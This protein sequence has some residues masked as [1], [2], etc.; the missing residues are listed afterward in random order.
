MK[1]FPLGRKR[2]CPEQPAIPSGIRVYAIG[3]VHGR[4]DLLVA[5]LAR[6][7]R[8]DASRPAADTRV[9]ML[10]DL[11]DRGPHSAEVIEFLLKARPSFA[12]FHFLMG[13]HE[14]AMLESLASEADP[15]STGWLRFGGMETLESYDVPEQAFGCSGRLFSDE[16]R[17][18]V[19]AAHLAFMREF[20]DKLLIGDYLFVHAGIRPGV[21]IEKQ[22]MEDKLWI[23]DDFLED[24]SDHGF[25]VVHGHTVHPEPDFRENRIGIDTGA[26]RTGVLTALALEGNERRIIAVGAP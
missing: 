21:S 3:D 14:Q 25:V 20:E 12:S 13:N 24:P 22:S 11:I 7:E 16:L 5:L 23:R 1:W 17:R 8:D 2:R 15:R 9:V 19:P 10:G 26:Y 4:L 6:V 18:Y